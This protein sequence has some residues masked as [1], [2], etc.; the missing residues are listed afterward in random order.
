MR[1]TLKYYLLSIAIFGITFSGVMLLL[2]IFF[3]GTDDR[4]YFLKL[5]IAVALGQLASPMVKSSQTQSG[6]EVELW[7][8]FL[9]KKKRIR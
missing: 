5:I 8:V 4:A 7:W 1:K 6:K 2:D 3:K 9:N